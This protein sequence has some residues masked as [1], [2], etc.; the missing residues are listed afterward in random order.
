MSKSS[1]AVVV[2]HLPAGASQTQALIVGSR[3]LESASCMRYQ[4]WHPYQLLQVPLSYSHLSIFVWLA[5]SSA[6]GTHTPGLRG[7][8]PAATGSN[9]QGTPFALQVLQLNISHR[10]NRG[11]TVGA[12]TNLINAGLAAHLKDSILGCSEQGRCERVELGMLQAGA[13]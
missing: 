7:V 11:C 12:Q 3:L 13:G 9:T 10:R 6:S 1:V 8:N 2:L 5:A 4:Q